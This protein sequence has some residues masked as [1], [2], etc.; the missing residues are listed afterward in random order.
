MRQEKATPKE[1]VAVILFAALANAVFFGVLLGLAWY[2]IDY[3]KWFGFVLYTGLVFGVLVYICGEELRKT[4]SLSVFTV[5]LAIHVV[6]VVVYLR[7]RKEL[8]G[9][10]FFFFFG[11]LE[12]GIGAFI[13]GTVGGVRPRLLRHRKYRPRGEFWTDREDNEKGSR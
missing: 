3:E 6:A 5:L 4:R 2:N 8:P 1:K 12:V 11:P 10:L 13:M 9:V 7:S